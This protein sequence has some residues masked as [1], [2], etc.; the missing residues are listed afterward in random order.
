MNDFGVGPIFA[1]YPDLDPDDATA[2]LLEIG[3]PGREP[4][5]ASHRIPYKFNKAY[6]FIYSSLTQTAST[7]T[8]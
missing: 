6:K 1:T 4:I 2:W 8:A 7:Q 3:H 5:I